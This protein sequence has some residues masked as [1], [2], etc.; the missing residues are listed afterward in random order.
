[1]CFVSE[2]S[3]REYG[4]LQNYVLNQITMLHLSPTSDR[5]HDIQCVQFH[6]LWV[7]STNIYGSFQ[8]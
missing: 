8:L 3:T 7:T 4:S 6:K 1:M 2:N 5:C